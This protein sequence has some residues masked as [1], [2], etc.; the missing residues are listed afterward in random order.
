MPTPSN[1]VNRSSLFIDSEC[2]GCPLFD[3][4]RGS[5]STPC[6]PTSASDDGHIIYRTERG[7]DDPFNDT[8]QHGRSLSG[9][10]IDQRETTFPLFV[11]TRTRELASHIR[12]NARW[13][14]VSLKFLLS[15][16]KSPVGTVHPSLSSANDLRRRLR[17]GKHTQ[18][19][20]VLNGEDDQLERLWTMNRGDLYEALRRHG[21][22]GVTGP[23]FSITS[24]HHPDFYVPASHNVA[25]LM[26][27]HRV[28]SEIPRSMSAIGIERCTRSPATSLARRTGR[29]LVESLPG[30]SIS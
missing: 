10:S 11:P 27:H 28:L 2:S 25:M 21:F 29:A 7:R 15:E 6:R 8:L 5:S 22:A 12:L 13:A 9:V 4:C 16:G 26:R 24:E 1:F 3:E 18:L 30:Y 20:A 19:L 23:T 14:A 17:V